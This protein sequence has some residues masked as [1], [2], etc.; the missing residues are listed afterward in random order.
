MEGLGIVT[1]NNSACLPL[2]AAGVDR[3]GE[4]GCL[5]VGS[6]RIRREARLCGG[7]VQGRQIGGCTRSSRRQRCVRP[8]RWAFY[9]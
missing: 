4:D 1:F 8:D 2:A 9:K 5:S 6:P 7:Q 3:E